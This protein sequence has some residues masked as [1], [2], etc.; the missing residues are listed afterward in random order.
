[1]THIVAPSADATE[2]LKGIFPDLQ[3]ETIPHPHVG[4]AY[5]AAPRK[6]TDSD[7]IVIGALGPHKGSARLLEIAKRARLTHPKL[8]FHLL[9]FSDIDTELREVGNVTVTGEYKPV[10]LGKLIE[11]AGGR[12]ALFLHGWP[13]TFSYTLSEAVEHGLIPIV[14][15]I[16]APAERVRASGFGV[17]FPF[18]FT[19]AQVLDTIAAVADGRV[20]TQAADGSPT[21]YDTPDSVA[22]IAA[23]LGVK[24]KTRKSPTV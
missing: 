8:R 22:R 9:G 12:L 3:T 5:P 19:A 7:V 15:D 13:E 2:Q 4:E 16:G 17:V 24:T 14:P 1:M 23:V 6:G 18:P 20:K 21:R 11:K 10:Q